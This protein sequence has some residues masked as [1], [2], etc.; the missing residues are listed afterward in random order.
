MGS[1]AQTQGPGRSD[2]GVPYSVA[3]ATHVH[4]EGGGLVTDTHTETA[5]TSTL[6]RVCQATQPLPAPAP[7]GGRPGWPPTG[8][9]GCPSGWLAQG[10]WPAFQVWVQGHSCGQSA[11]R[12][13]GSPVTPVSVRLGSTLQKQPGGHLSG[14]HGRHPSPS[15]DSWEGGRRNPFGLGTGVRNGSSWVRW[16]E[17]GPSLG[18]PSENGASPQRRLLPLASRHGG[19]RAQ[20][21]WCPDRAVP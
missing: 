19:L 7:Q 14:A 9:S 10:F 13:H 11:P 17:K 12:V 5:A 15:P 2:R 1:P 8:Q 21:E 18:S 3:A 4:I 16:V 20:A 6:P